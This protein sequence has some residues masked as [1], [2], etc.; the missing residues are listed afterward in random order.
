[1]SEA[2]RIGLLISS[3]LFFTSKVT[4]TAQALGLHVESVSNLDQ[5]QAASATG[6]VGAVFLDLASGGVSVSEV[7]AALPPASSIPII[8]FGSHVNVEQLAAAQAAG[9]SVL[10]RSR[11]SA[12]LPALLSSLLRAG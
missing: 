12:E 5:L 6:N 11:F 8:A 10:P 7:S 3:D 4:G 2:P 1:M 9:A